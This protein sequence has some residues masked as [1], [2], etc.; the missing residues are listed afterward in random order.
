MTVEGCR[1]WRERLG[2]YVL[3]QLSED[4][5][6]ATAAHIDG[7]AACRA[8]AESLAPI[9]ELLAEGRSGPARHGPRPARRA[10]RADQLRDRRRARPQP[11]AQRRG[12]GG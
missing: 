3:D 8:E 7:C 11:P 1:E 6:A 10:R 9:A 12:A 4:E 5:R 2:A